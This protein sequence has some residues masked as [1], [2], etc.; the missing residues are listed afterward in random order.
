[1]EDRPFMDKSVNEIAVT[2]RVAQEQLRQI[3]EGIDHRTVPTA[4]KVRDRILGF[5]REVVEDAEPPKEPEIGVYVI[6][7]D[8][9][10]LRYKPF[11]KRNGKT[12]LP[13]RDCLYVGHSLL[14][15]EHRFMQH[16][17]GQHASKIVRRYGLRLRPEF[18]DAI[19]PFVER[20]DAEAKEEELGEL[21]RSEGYAVWYN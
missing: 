13:G 7:L 11:M 19:D 3:W 12:Y 18:Y 4:A 16:L 17:R 14:A 5:A 1:M 8:Q 9:K 15:P 6:E 21:L 2:A 20:E 10:V